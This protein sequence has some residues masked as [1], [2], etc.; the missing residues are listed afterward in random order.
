MQAM[1]LSPDVNDCHF[2]PHGYSSLPYCW[3]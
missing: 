2:L 3:S 1:T